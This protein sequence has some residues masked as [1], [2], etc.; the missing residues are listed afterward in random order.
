MI[1]IF[2]GQQEGDGQCV[3]GDDRIIEI[4]EDRFTAFRRKDI[5]RKFLDRCVDPQVVAELERGR[6]EEGSD[7]DQYCQRTT[8]LFGQDV[9]GRLV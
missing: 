5:A 7:S 9:Q 4:R 1:Q 3:E 8:D 6:N 2:E